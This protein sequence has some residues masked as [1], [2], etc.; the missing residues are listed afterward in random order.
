MTDKQI[1]NVK[2]AVRGA[3]S[4]MSSD[5]LRVLRVGSYLDLRSNA[6]ETSQAA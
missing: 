3:I 5:S 2:D 1:Q 6:L 4:E